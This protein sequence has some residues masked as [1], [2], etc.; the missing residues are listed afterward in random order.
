[1]EDNGNSLKVEKIPVDVTMI[2]R[3]GEE[4]TGTI[5]LDMHSRTHA[6]PE[7]ISDVLNAGA[8]FIP[9]VLKDG[10]TVLLNRRRIVTGCCRAEDDESDALALGIVSD[11]SAG[12]RLEDGRTLNGMVRMEMH[13]ENTRLSDILNG[14][15]DFIRVRD[16][17]T[18]NFVNRAYVNWFMET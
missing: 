8:E 9:L 6:G 14:N 15:E 2:M 3:G 1:M 10:R 18:D 5:F 16:A 11:I 7:R 13:R 17:G 4:L 12:I